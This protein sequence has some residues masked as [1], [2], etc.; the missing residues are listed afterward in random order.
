MRRI[1]QPSA[2]AVA[3]ATAALIIYDI[4]GRGY[5]QKMAVMEPVWPVTAL[6]LG[7]AAWWA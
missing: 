7:P 6:Y 1:A 3:G 5:R 2:L 4:D